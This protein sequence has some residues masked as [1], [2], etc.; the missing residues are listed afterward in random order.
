[1]GLSQTLNG[2]AAQV[3]RLAR[4]LIVDGE[5]RLRRLR[6]AAPRLHLSLEPLLER[7]RS[8]DNCCENLSEEESVVQ[9]MLQMLLG[10]ML[11]WLSKQGCRSY[12]T[13]SS[14]VSRRFSPLDAL[15][16]SCWFSLLLPRRIRAFPRVQT[17]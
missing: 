14:T 3:E 6:D 10:L 4:A 15:F 1:M 17:R 11:Q 12:L 9:A 13:V 16:P 7:V 5:Q 2:S 8:R